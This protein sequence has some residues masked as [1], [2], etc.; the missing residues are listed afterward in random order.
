MNKN[1]EDSNV[2]SQISSFSE[3][4]LPKFLLDNLKKLDWQNPTPIQAQAI[5]VAISGNDILGISKTGSGKSASFIIPIIEKLSGKR[6]KARM[7]RAIII[8]PTREIA[9]QSYELFNNLTKHS[10]LSAALL[11]GGDNINTQIK[12][13]NKDVDVLIVT[14]GRILDLFE[15]GK[16]LLNDVKI[17]VID[18]ADR[19]LDMGFFPDISQIVSKLPKSRQTLFFSATKNQDL[20]K[21]Q[22]DFLNNPTT[23]EIKTQ[24]SSDKSEI[25]QFALT[26]KAGSKGGESI[27]SKKKNIIVDLI[28]QYQIAEA[29]IFCN[30]K[31]DMGSLEDFL[32]KN[33]LSASVMHGD[34][35]QTERRTILTDF[36]NKKTNFLICSDLVA[37]G[38]DV[39]DMPCVINHDI[40]NKAEDY[41]HRIG[42]SGRAGNNGIAWS[43]IADIDAKNIDKILQLDNVD[44]KLGKLKGFRNTNIG[45]KL[46]TITQAEIEKIH[47]SIFG[48]AL[49]E[50]IQE[51]PKEA[52]QEVSSKKE[53]LQEELQ[54]EKPKKQ[55]RKRTRRAKEPEI[56]D[57]AAESQEQ[58]RK[59]ARRKQEDV[60]TNESSQNEQEQKQENKKQASVPKTYVKV[61]VKKLNVPPI[62]RNPEGR[63]IGMG[64]HVPK[65]MLQEIE[66]DK[67]ILFSTADEE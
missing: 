37:R 51:A 47:E 36:K 60:E 31:R 19:M 5:P 29:I 61:A 38:I 20:N 49:Q 30:K 18:E 17:L 9:E 43:I 48:Q 53:D 23:I 40:P 24:D 59:R 11:I 1:T 34:L 44:L 65:F 67:S 62:R 39:E 7:P 41:I 66:I 54:T 16:L 33:N 13:L 52:I 14:A 57:K 28:K 55:A 32:I 21:Y 26:V 63:I 42:R 46:P 56:D 15:R 6:S 58:V 64:D 45:I 27:N 35:S 22:N 3:I 12:Q 8:S 4:K 2:V 10:K 25:Y 50:D